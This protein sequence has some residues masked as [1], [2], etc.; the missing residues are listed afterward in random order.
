VLRLALLSALLAA[1]AQV[2]PGG[3]PAEEKPDRLPQI[4]VQSELVELDVVVT[5]SQDRPVT[6]LGQESFEVL[7]DGHPRPITHFAPG[8]ARAPSAAAAPPAGQAPRPAAFPEEAAPHVRHLVLAVDDYH[9]QPEEL[10]SVRKALLRFIDSQLGAGDQAVVVAASGSLGALQQFTTDR[11][12]LRRAVARL[13]AQ[14]RSFRPP[15][16]VPRITD[17][18][19]E[20]I[21]TG[22][23]DALSLAVEEIMAT[24]PSSRQSVSDQ[25][26]NEQRVRTMARQIVASNARVTSMTLASLERLVRT[27]LPVRGRKVVALFSSGFFLGT[28]R[29]SSQHDLQVIADAAARSG[30]AFYTIDARGL[31]AT[32]GVFDA[33]IGG[34]Y[35]NAMNP[36]AN[37]GVRER[38]EARAV[39]AARDG[40]N[41]LAVDTGGLAFFNRNDLQ[42]PLERVLEDS[43]T[44]YRLGFEPPTSPRDGRFH[45]IEVRVP[46]HPGLRVRTASGYFAGGSAPAE[47]KAATAAG[48]EGEAT[49]L[50]STALN[51]S[52]PLRALPVDLAA[53]FVG[54][55]AG[56]V[57]VAT[58]WVDATRLPFEAAAEGRESAAFDIVGVVIDENGKTVDQFS[59]RVELSLTAESKERAL[60]NGLTY[61]K[62]LAVPPG[63]LQARVAVRADKS[64]LLGSAS[65]WVEVPNRARAGLSLS[66]ILLVEEGEDPAAAP[67]G[68]RGVVSFDRPRQPEVS[69]RFP[70]GG[71]LDYLLVVYDR[72]KRGAA[73]PVDVVVESQ[74]LSGSTILTRSAPSPV[75]AEGLA[76]LPVTSGRLRLDAFAPGDYEL[77]LVVSDRATNATASRSLRFTVE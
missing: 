29:Q 52:Y 36:D 17:Y 53:D 19:A 76:G 10:S 74:L 50:L 11:E 71:H 68:S 41:A 63:L 24:E 46:G 57:V 43:A 60:H 40:L 6:D 27:L 42:A 28:G 45:K 32:P 67:P 47:S 51:S 7:E 69:R 72:G 18:Q 31:I 73:S 23:Q 49:R 55:N 61:R 65:Q 25:T 30:V 1:A 44:Y 54:T 12:V 70:R 33:R 15:V 35:K 22:D 26:R 75:A 56:D 20:L 16:E 9:L 39:E 3:P 14:N 8:F 77:R 21:E 64:G 58:A 38:I 48:T 34:S 2:P 5:D 4:G 37:P 13:R 66:S 62:T 59:D